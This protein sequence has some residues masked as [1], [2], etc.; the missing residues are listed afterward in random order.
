MFADANFVKCHS[1]SRLNAN[2]PVPDDE[3]PYWIWYP[4]IP[5]HCT[6][7]KLA[8][9]RAAMR[10]QCARACI[11]GGYRETYTKIIDMPGPSTD[12]PVDPDDIYEHIPPLADGCLIAE[13]ESSRFRDFFLQDMERRWEERGLKPQFP[14][15]DDWK[16][17]FP[18]LC[19]DPS[20]T[21][22]Y[23]SLPDRGYCIAQIG[24]LACG[25]S[26]GRN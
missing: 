13:A 18:W 9:A 24:G 11:A 23:G 2:Q 19:R 25:G 5:S 1:E 3:L 22:L 16:L 14:E 8:E 26:M 17:L 15:Y 6:L 7:C 10:S 4:T 21:I 20:N 12:I